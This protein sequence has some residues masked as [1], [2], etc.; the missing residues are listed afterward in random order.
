MFSIYTQQSPFYQDTDY[1]NTKAIP[2]R[3]SDAN[4]EYSPLSPR[5]VSP[6]SQTASVLGSSYGSNASISTL[7]SSS[8]KTNYRQL[9]QKLEQDPRLFNTIFHQ[10]IGNFNSIAAD[11]AGNYLCQA[12]VE[13]ANNDQM[14]N[15][16]TRMSS[17]WLGIVNHPH[18]TRVAQKMAECLRVPSQH[19]IFVQNCMENLTEMIRHNNGNHVVRKVVQ[20]FPFHYSSCV[21]QAFLDN[22]DIYSRD[23]YG[24][25]VIQN[26]LDA[27]SEQTRQLFYTHLQ[28]RA[29][30]MITDKFA[31]YLV[32]YVLD[33]ASKP[34]VEEWI[35]M[36]LPE[37]FRLCQDQCASNVIEKAIKYSSPMLRNILIDELVGRASELALDPFGNYVLQTALEY[38]ERS[39][40]ISMSNA[41]ISSESELKMTPFVYYFNLGT[42]CSQ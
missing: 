6:L 33:K 26:A 34:I 40:F 10:V 8:K 19:S 31:N 30:N 37:L 35:L 1:L 3:K 36:F 2:I 27:S 14:G 39:S 29:M 11:P 9:A 20:H 4:T 41:L 22:L 16:L 28:P 13:H 17:N 15:M 24:V 5:S 32:Q 7:T 38:S 12:L 23:K 42:K 21:Y 18:G 25:C